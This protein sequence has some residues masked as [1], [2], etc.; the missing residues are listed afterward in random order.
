MSLLTLINESF[1][2]NRDPD[3]GVFVWTRGGGILSG[4]IKQCDN[5]G[6]ILET[7]AGVVLVIP[8]S[9]VA[10]S[11]RREALAGAMTAAPSST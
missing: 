1:P 4:R 10:I 8:R 5:R 6:L 11:D 7:A 3:G 2:R 9:V